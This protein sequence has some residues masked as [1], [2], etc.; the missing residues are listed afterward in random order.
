[1]ELS[2][3][4]G[5]VQHKE[6]PDKQLAELAKIADLRMYEAKQAHYRTG[7]ADRRRR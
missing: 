4:C 6:F 2:I 1:M 3:S 5:Y 7:G